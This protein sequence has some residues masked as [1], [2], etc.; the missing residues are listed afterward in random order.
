[1]SINKLETLRK[2]GNFTPAKPFSESREI[3]QKTKFK[4]KNDV[5]ADETSDETSQYIPA[6][7]QRKTLKVSPKTKVEI[8]ELKRYVKMEYN[9]EVIQFLIDNYVADHLSSSEKRRFKEN[10]E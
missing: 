6:T 4:E 3:P 1:M 8:E 10:T 9:Y 5:K 2:K 7:N